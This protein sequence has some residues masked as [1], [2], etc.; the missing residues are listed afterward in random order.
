MTT[1][2]TTTT[3]EQTIPAGTWEIDPLHSSIG[4]EVKHLGISTFRGGFSDFDGSVEVGED[5]LAA[6]H[7]SIRT[8]SIDIND[9]QLG[10]HLRSPDFFDVATH[11]EATFESTAIARVGDEEYRVVGDFTL[12]GVTRPVELD[13]RADGI[14]VDPAG[15]DRISLVG[16]GIVDRTEYGLDWNSTLANGAA[17]VAEKVRLVL[18]VEAV[19]S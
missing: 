9:E 12:R 7:G 13:V 18:S 6:I 4:F 16:E 3:V 1:T 8:D 17:A 10:G 2:T 14:G 5:G 11:P 19:R 15:S